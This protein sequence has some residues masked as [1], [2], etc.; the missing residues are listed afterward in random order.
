MFFFIKIEFFTI[1]LEQLSKEGVLL[2][3]PLKEEMK[4]ML[5]EI[6]LFAIAVNILWNVWCIKSSI[7]VSRDI[8]Y[9]VSRILISRFRISEINDFWVSWVKQTNKTLKVWTSFILIFIKFFALIS[10][11]HNYSTEN[12]ILAIVY[13]SWRYLN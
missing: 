12:N 10:L 8:A 9:R 5:I 1:Y 13:L 4:S 7:T 3:R 6:S 2:Q 11:S